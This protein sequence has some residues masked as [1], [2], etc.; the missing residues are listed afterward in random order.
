MRTLIY[1]N[2]NGP[3]TGI[4][5]RS[6]K[7]HIIYSIGAHAIAVV[8]VLRIDTSDPSLDKIVLYTL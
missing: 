5:E 4:N 3:C 6:E 7:L 1:N 8:V 2:N